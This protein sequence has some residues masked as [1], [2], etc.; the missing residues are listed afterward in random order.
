MT[1]IN[2]FVD[3]YA[4]LSNFWQA[5]V[6]TYDW[7]YLTAEHAF[8]SL[9]METDYDAE[10]VRQAKTPGQAKRLGRKLPMKGNWNNIKL[11]VMQDILIDKF[12]DPELQSMLLATG[13][14]ML[15]EGNPWGDTFWGI[16]N[17]NGLNHLGRLLMAVRLYYQETT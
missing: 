10:L 16:S 13:D 7:I 11:H 9:K 17:G 5:P 12:A 14:A 15:I 8:Q 6:R 3:E 2:R 1:T 4:F